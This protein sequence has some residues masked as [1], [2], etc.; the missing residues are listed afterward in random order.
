MSKT[1]VVIPDSHAHPDYSN[2]RYDYLGHFISD[3]KPDYVVDIGDWFD[4]PSL[5]SYDKGKSSFEGRRYWK[6][7]ETGIEAQDRMLSVIRRQKRK[8]PSFHRTLGNH[9]ARITR[10]ISQDAAVLEGTIGLEDLQSA[11]YKWEEYP[12]LQ[13][14]RIEGVS[15]CHYFTTGVK[16]M[17]I[18][19]EHQAYTLLMKE[20]A[21]CVMGHTHTLDYAVRRAG[22]RFIHGLVVGCFQD[23]DADYAGPANKKWNRGVVKLTNVDNG[24]FDFSWISMERLHEAYGKR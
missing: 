12:F 20:H 16:N 24:N 15:F 1:I 14:V 6:D 23:Y 8:L 21:S 9:E 11:E 17:P 10:A 2:R 5:C 7:I 13:P 18:G 3:V 19:G 4:M 22:E